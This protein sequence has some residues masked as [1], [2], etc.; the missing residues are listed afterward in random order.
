MAEG[1]AII[2]AVE[3]RER[4]AVFR[5]RTDGGEALGELLRAEPEDALVLAIPSGGVP[6]A[7][8]LCRRLDLPLDVAVVSKITLPWDTEAG[9]G[10]VAFDGS[11]R[12]NERLL[13]FLDLSREQIEDGL[14]RTRAKVER[15]VRALRGATSAPPVAGR[16]VILVDD[17]LASGLTMEVAIAA[18][19]RAGASRVA[20]AVPTAHREAAE[21]V[22]PLAD[23]LYCGN[24]RSGRSF[25]VADAYASW[26]DVEEEAAAELLAA[27]RRASEHVRL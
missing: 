19:R 6:V 9:Y 13:P 10:A 4:V 21:R 17:G 7:V 1:A 12:L 5:D 27:H 24:L 15:R 8:A 2:D 20:V 25:A 3:R 26:C 23:A 18:V 11:S 14:A 22:A 16:A